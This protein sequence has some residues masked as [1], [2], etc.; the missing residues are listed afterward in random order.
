MVEAPAKQRRRE[1]V[2][3]PERICANPDCTVVFK[4]IRET[5]MFHAPD[6]RKAHWRKAYHWTPHPCPLCTVVHDPEEKPML[7]A[8]EHWIGEN[9]MPGT[10]GAYDQLWAQDLKS[11]IT[12]RRAILHG[13]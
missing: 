6:C 5:Q 3:H 12:G 10:G 11:W 13:G 7:D 8:L 9:A 2:D 4:P 1:P